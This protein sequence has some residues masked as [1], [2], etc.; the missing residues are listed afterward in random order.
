[1]N[2]DLINK[3][4]IPKPKDYDGLFDGE[5]YEKEPYFE[6]NK[7]LKYKKKEMAQSIK[8]NLENGLRLIERFLNKLL[9]DIIEPDKPLPKINI[10]KFGIMFFII[11][12]I[13]IILLWIF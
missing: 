5:G 13:L 1:M 10:S 11:T 3:E 2:E 12:L 9:I 6:K 7:E 8:L 4:D